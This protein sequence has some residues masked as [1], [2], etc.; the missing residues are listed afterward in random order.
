MMLLREL[1]LED[2]IGYNP[3]L[4]EFYKV[5]KASKTYKANKSDYDYYSIRDNCGVAAND[6]VK[7]V[8]EFF[9]DLHFKRVEGAFKCDQVLY[10]KKD[11]TKEMSKELISLGLD[12]NNPEHRK[13]FLENDE[14]Y[15]EEWKHCPHYWCVSMTEGNKIYDPSGYMQFILTGKAKDL[16]PNRYIKDYAF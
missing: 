5:A 8:D 11:F 15:A 10:D 6:L 9:P 7:F 1:L 14:R 4:A 12:F 3:V 2:G 13:S 16:H